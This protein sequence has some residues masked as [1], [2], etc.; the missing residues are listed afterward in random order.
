MDTTFSKK[1]LIITAIALIAIVLLVRH[2]ARNQAPINPDAGVPPETQLWPSTQV[3]Q[4]SIVE[5]TGPYTI[6]VVYPVTQSASINESFKTFAT[7]QVDQFKQDTAWVNDQPDTAQAQDLAL[8]MSYTQERSTHADN[9][10]FT[11]ASYTGGAHGLQA[12]KTFSFTDTGMPIGLES[13]FIDQTKGLALVSEYAKQ[14]L[15][16]REFAD[17]SWIADGAAPTA[18]NY[19]SFVITDTGIRFLFDPYQVAPYAAGMQT[20]DVPT[21]VFRTI[22]NPAL[23]TL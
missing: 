22:A 7:T 14:V 12:T 8:T 4:A 15:S 18:D 20:V 17:A 13:I 23:F 21:N 10:I 3:Q 16:K 6:N 5:T 19:A 2:T 9:Y 11:I 1:H